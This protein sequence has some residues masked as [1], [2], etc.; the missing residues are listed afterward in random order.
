MYF[1][2][3]IGSIESIRLGVFFISNKI[4]E[5]NFT[6]VAITVLSIVPE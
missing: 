3:I 2:T 5:N 1:E 4:F 6:H